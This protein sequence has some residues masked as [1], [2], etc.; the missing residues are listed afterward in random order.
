MV[1]LFTNDGGEKFVPA[2][3]IKSMKDSWVVGGLPQMAMELNTFVYQR[4]RIILIDLLFNINL[5][6]IALNIEQKIWYLVTLQNCMMLHALFV[7]F[8]GLPRW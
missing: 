6:Y 7:V 4:I 3:L 5:I 1:V 2:V 8:Q